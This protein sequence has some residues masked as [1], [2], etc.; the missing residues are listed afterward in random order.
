MQPQI[1]STPVTSVVIEDSIPDGRVKQ[2]SRLWQSIVGL[3]GSNK[4]MS[5]GLALVG[6]FLLVAIV[7][8]LFI[9]EGPNPFTNDIF[10]APSTHHLL[11]TTSKGED[12]FTQLVL[13]AWPTLFIGLVSGILATMLSII[14]GLTAG[15]FGGWIDDVLSLVINIFIVLPGL[16]LAVVI[17]SLTNAQ[18]KGSWSLIIVLFL[19]TWAWGA[20]VLRAQTLSMRRREF[21]GAAQAVGETPLRVIFAEIL[22]NEIALVAAS[23]VSTVVYTLLAEIALQFLGLGDVSV[24]SWGAMLFWAQTNQALLAGA[25][26]W[27]LPP[28][29]CMALVGAGLSLINFGIDELANPRLRIETGRKKGAGR[30]NPN[31]RI[32]PA[33]AV[34]KGVA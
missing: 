20:R 24:N 4:K 17:A 7:G 9:H 8:P 26:W 12:V 33:P 29:L 34:E 19:T 11:G 6:F 30:V 15:Y 21:V 2:R 13:G 18:F 23:F 5:I 16:P 31:G 14:F 25:W 28:G 1:E 22:P 32:N 10:Q 3:L 27:F